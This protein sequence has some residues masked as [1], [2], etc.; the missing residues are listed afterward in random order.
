VPDDDGLLSRYCPPVRIPALSKK[1]EGA[2][3]QQERPGQV[4]AAL[5]ALFGS[6]A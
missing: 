5:L 1:A 2:T 3:M 4:D 6:L